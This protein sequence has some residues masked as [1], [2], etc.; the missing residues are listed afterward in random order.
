MI[1]NILFVYS[2]KNTQTI[3]DLIN[4]NWWTYFIPFINLFI[5]LMIPIYYLSILIEYKWENFKNTK[6]K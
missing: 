4:E 1:L 6:I 5:C 2:D 3:G